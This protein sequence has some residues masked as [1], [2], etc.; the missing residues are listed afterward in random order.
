VF[1]FVVYACAFEEGC[2]GA[3]GGA[4]GHG[5]GGRMGQGVTLEMVISTLVSQTN[6]A[7]LDQ[8]DVRE[9]K[10]KA[11]QFGLRKHVSMF[12]PIFRGRHDWVNYDLVMT[13][14]TSHDF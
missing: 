2:G 4:D 11:R 13:I 1:I 14:V 9:P 7:W 5:E 3:G 8:R 10:R 12:S 6:H